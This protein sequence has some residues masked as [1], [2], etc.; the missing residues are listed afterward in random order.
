[1][2]RSLKFLLIIAV[3]SVV[4]AGIWYTRFRE[5]PIAVSVQPVERGRVETLIANTQA[6]SVRACRRAKLSPAMGGQIAHLPAQEGDRVKQGQVLLEL[7]NQDLRAQI[8]LAKQQAVAAVASMEESCF[9]AD[10]AQRD[11]QRQ[12][13]LREQKLVAE[14]SVDRAVSVAKARAANCQAAR[15]NEKVA[16]DQ[17]NVA[18]AALER[19]LLRA[20]FDGVVAEINGEVGEF[21]TP[22]PVGVVT[23]P[24]VDVV[25]TN[26]LYITSPIDEVDAANV[27]IGMPARITLDAFRNQSFAG[28]VRRIAPY[29]Q[30]LEKQA[31]TV[32]VE[33]EFA[34][35][36]QLQK[37]LPGY[38]ADAEI[39][40]DAHENALRIPTDAVLQ[41]SRVL[42]LDNSGILKERTIKT[43]LMNWKYTEVLAG[44][45][46][47][48]QIV[49]SVGRE[50]V[51]NGIKA[52]IEND[53]A[54][55][56][57]E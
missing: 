52:V 53:T 37:L 1:M 56:S 26:C 55:A 43:G 12:S 5:D 47:G 40:V 29:I 9:T 14:E 17:I 18:D 11:A 48:E 30:E 41:E 15:A 34:E 25:D 36:E 16:R 38:S 24:A 35:K 20:P 27:H 8:T 19:S 2:R 23:P 42:V 21:V 49:T 7:W 32:D 44:L 50:G 46:E 3:I 31:R 39:I 51:K 22:S 13:K 28:T 6:G 10:Q 57:K 45:T 33:I 4:I 54:T